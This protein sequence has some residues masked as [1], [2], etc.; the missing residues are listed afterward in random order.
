MRAG[1]D[2]DVVAK[3]PVV[4]VVLA[5]V[6]WAGVG[7]HLVAL[8][9]RSL[10]GC[11]QVVE[12]VKGRVFVGQAL[13]RLGGKTGVGLHREVIEREVGRLEGQ[14]GVQVVLQVGHGLAGQGV[15]QVD[16]EGVE[17]NARFFD[18]GLGLIAV[19]HAAQGLEFGIVKT[20]HAD[21]QSVHAG[22]SKALETVF[23]EGARVGLQG[24]FAAGLQGQARADVGQ[25][26]VD[27]GGREQA[28]RA[29]ADE[30]GVHLA[31]PHQGQGGFQVGHEGGQVAR[32]GQL[33]AAGP[34]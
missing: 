34:L 1:A 19:V 29:P 17:R 23:L 32:F 26:A 3:L 4:Q 15:H 33:G 5:L 21:G 14:G 25:Q 10:G 20:L 8:H 31:A 7:R 2:A 28:G 9:A 24:D 30:D 12:H 27:A 11:H 22:V 6:A 13:G 18:G 16:V